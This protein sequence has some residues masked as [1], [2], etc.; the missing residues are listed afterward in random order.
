MV[1]YSVNRIYLYNFINKSTEEISFP[2]EEIFPIRI[3]L[4]DNLLIYVAEDG[5]NLLGDLSLYY[6][7]LNTKIHK[8]IDNLLFK[9]DNNFS[10]ASFGFIDV[11][12]GKIIY[13]KSYYVTRIN[14]MYFLMSNLF[15]YDI[16]KNIT[17]KVAEDSN[18]QYHPIV[19]DGQIAYTSNGTFDYVSIYD[20][21]TNQKTQLSPPHIGPV[22]DFNAGKLLYFD[23]NNPVEGAYYLYDINNRSYQ[24]I[25][26]KKKS[27]NDFFSMEVREI[28]N[29]FLFLEAMKYKAGIGEQIIYFVNSSSD[30]KIIGYD[31]KLNRYVEINQFTKSGSLDV[32]NKKLCFLAADYNIYCHEYNESYSYPKQRLQSLRVIGGYDFVNHDNDPMD[33]HGHGTHVAGIAAGD[34]EGSLRGVAPDVKLYAYK[35]L[36]S[37][38]FGY[39]NDIISAINM[40][41]DPNQDGDYSDKLDII[42]LSLG[43]DCGGVYDAYCGPDDPPSQ[44]IDNVVSA[45]IIAVI[46]AG[47]NGDYSKAIATP[48]TARKA[49]TVG[50]TDKSDRIAYFSA[51]GPVNW[52]DESDREQYISKPDIVAP[53]VNIC[54]AEYDSAWNDRKC[55]D[56]KHVAISGTSMATPHVAGA[57]A[58]LKQK[59]PSWNAEEIKTALKNT[60]KNLGYNSDIQGFG[61]IDISKAIQLNDAPLL[62]KIY[63]VYTSDKT[64]NIFGT[65][66]GNN[67]Q[68][69]NIYYGKGGNSL[70]VSMWIE[71]QRGGVQKDNDI[72]YEN[73]NLSNLSIGSYYFKISVKGL[74]KNSTDLYRINV[75]KKNNNITKI[76]NWDSFKGPAFIDG[77]RI[78]WTDDKYSSFHDDILLCDLNGSKGNITEW[79]SSFS[80]NGGLKKI[81]TGGASP[82]VIIS[83]DKIFW[84]E[85]GRIIM[86]D[87]KNNK[88]EIIAYGDG[89]NIYPILISAEDSIVIYQKMIYNDVNPI[90]IFM[91][92]L[93]GS[94]GNITEWCSS[95]SPNGGLKQIYNPNEESF[96]QDFPS[97]SNNKI[98]FVHDNRSKSSVYIYDILEKNL[99]T[100]SE[101]LINFNTLISL[102]K[103]TWFE[104]DGFINNEIYVYDLNQSKKI[105]IRRNLI[106]YYMNSLKMWRFNSISGNRVVWVDYGRGINYDSDIYM[107]DI[108]NNQ[109]IP[110]INQEGYNQRN[111]SI[112]GDKLVFTDEKD[113]QIY[114]YE[115]TQSSPSKPQSKIVNN[116]NFTINGQLEIFLQKNVS[117]NWQD[118]KLVVDKTVSIPANGLLKLDIG[119][120]NLGNQVYEGFNNLNATA[121]SAGDYRVYARFE[122]NGKFVEG[123]WEFKVA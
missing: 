52:K 70:N 51:K 3:K 78:I 36:D 63:L 49:I 13:G 109:E 25:N 23:C 68:E 92:D 20:L 5:S 62:A 84:H 33:D 82:Y 77:N 75:V 45:G 67:F 81:A 11:S 28:G 108:L 85:W 97:I 100:I 101:G 71:I 83:G 60:A 27:C 58:L 1:Y 44:A 32:E 73:F 34:G 99:R 111:P 18:Y 26:T 2:S 31:E 94:K 43:A 40:S 117:G 93:N 56:D 55:L 4:K 87:L 106:Y 112:S 8:K 22:L 107:Y 50:A 86:Y 98:A 19:S 30:R 80:P 35:V 74:N 119:K 122:S 114:L 12:Q 120:D 79:C 47:N 102:D 96:A 29:G 7:D 104:N 89:Y 64:V 116:D 57:V 42:S 17:N 66:K 65:A 38:G 105:S 121:S 110:I 6:Y 61:R 16:E 76:T 53:G 21:R 54:S 115:F 48:G 88:E 41:I 72:L 46:A 103:I 37:Q 90:A 14:N 123:D 118:V 69:Y 91:C 15:V 9:D 95:F 59:N 113:E 39:F 10:R 24:K